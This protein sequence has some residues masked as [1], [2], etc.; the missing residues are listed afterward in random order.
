MGAQDLSRRAFLA[1]SGGAT[2][3]ASLPSWLAARSAFAAPHAAG[4]SRITVLVLS[5]DLYPSPDPQRFV[6]AL[7]KGK[8]IHYSSGPADEIGFAPEGHRVA[9]LAATTLYKRGLPKG[10]G[11]YRVDAAFPTAGVWSAVVTTDGKRVRFAI[12]VKDEAEA[13]VVG[14]QAPR[15]PSPTTRNTLGVN[16]ICTREPPCNL[17]QVSL[18]DAIGAGK[19]VAA[20]FATPALCQSQ[21]CG[22]V[23]DELLALVP[24]YKDRITFVH[25]DIYTS[26]ESQ[27]RKLAP[28]VQAYGLPSEPWLFGIDGSGIIRSRLDGAIGKDEIK[29]V[30]DQLVAT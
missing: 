15:A 30:L 2:I 12:Q 25:I 9:E 26:L 28:T 17:H 5:S 1:R 22:P 7:N 11:I 27:K 14:S 20:M 19:P 8:G 29:A 23:L 10:R 13:P 18:A 4:G 24:D 3:G 21:Y 16:P 6:F